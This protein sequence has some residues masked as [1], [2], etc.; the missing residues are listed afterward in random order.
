KQVRAQSLSGPSMTIIQGQQVPGMTNGDGAI[1]CV[2]L[3]GGTSLSGFTLTNGATRNTGDY[4]NEEAGGGV[5]CASLGI[6]VSNCVIVGNSAQTIAGGAY[7]GV[8]KNCILTGNSAQYNGGGASQ[9][10]LNNCALSGNFAQYSGG[11]ASDSTLNDCN[12]NTNS[13]Q[14]G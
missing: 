9:S 7:G 14:N 13:S 12:L 10:T 1:R 8:L 5:Y 6:V 11:G 2:Y 4:L 3:A